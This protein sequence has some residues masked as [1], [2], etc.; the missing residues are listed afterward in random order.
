MM[1]RFLTALAIALMILPGTWLFASGKSEGST[2]KM[3]IRGAEQVPN[4]ISPPV[5]DGQA[6]SL[7]SSIYDY[8]I[9]MDANTGKLVPALAT[10]WNSPDGKVWTFHLRKG[11]KFHD[12]SDFT[13]K[14]VKY[15]LGLTQDPKVGHLKAEDFKVVDKIETPDDY[16]VVITLKESIPTFPYQMT[17]YHMAM[18]SSDYPLDKLE[19]AP[20]GTGPFMLKKMVP[21]ESAQLVKNPNY[22]QKGLPKADELRIYFVPDIDA[23]VQMLENGDVDY[24]PQI[25]PVT[26]QRLESEKG[27]KVISPYTEY[28]FISMAMDRKPFDNNDVRLAF[29]YSMD[30][31]MLAKACHGTLGENIFYNETPIANQLP[32]YSKIPFRGQDYAKAKELLAKAGYPNGVKVELYYA[33]DHPYGANIAQTLKE[34]AAPAGFDLQLKGYTRDIYLSKYWMHGPLL[35]TGWGIRTDPSMLL[36]LA[37]DSKGPWNESHMNIPAVDT[38]IQKIRAEV[39]ST[40]RM[41]YYKQLQQIMHDQGTV[42]DLQVP[43]L[44][45]TSDRLIDYRQPLTM[46][47]QMK[48]AYIK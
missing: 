10:D 17:D 35:L 26:A 40:K 21:K 13:S 27:F 14:D 19:S 36:M 47:T 7:D 31:E 29:K 9:E 1:K 15:T 43:Y 24:V 28:R 25:S 46:L 20:M 8:L 23:S 3:I 44:V 39:D 2:G 45:G 33:S 41:E 48:Y 12:G 6:F 34:L 5:W 38:L 11:V 22:W 18:L 30:P 32:Q 16:T 42:I 37:F 4:L